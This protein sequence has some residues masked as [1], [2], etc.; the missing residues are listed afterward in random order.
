MKIRRGLLLC[1]SAAAALLA[2]APQVGKAQDQDSAEG[3]DEV[4]VTARKRAEDILQTPVAV[5]VLS[6]ADIDAKGII[7]LT[8]LANNTP[9]FQITSVNSGRNDRSFQQ[10]SLRGFTPS[11]TA[12]TLTAS[13][14]DGV[15]V[16]SAN[17]LNSVTQPARV[18]VLKGPQAAYFGRNAFAGAVNVVTK[19]PGEE[20]GGDLSLMGGSRGYWDLQGSL[21]GPLFSDKLGFRITGRTYSKDGGYANTAVPGQR[22]GDQSSDVFS[23]TLAAQPTDG[24]KIKLFGMLSQDDD[25]PSPEGFIS[26]YELRSNAGVLNIPSRSGSSAGTLIVPN[27]SNCV[28][29]N[30]PWFCGAIP[31]LL[32]GFG[33]AQ[34]SANNAISANSLASGNQ[35]VIDPREGAKGYGL[36]AEFQH[37]HLTIDWDIGDS[38]FTL[39]SLTGIN[40][41]FV[42]QSDD[43]DNWDNSS[44]I[45]PANAMGTN[46]NANTFWNFPFMVEREER[47]F[48]QEFRLSFDRDGPFSGL[49]GVSYLKASA[50]SG[51]LN[52]SAEYTAGM[53][54]SQRAATS[55][56]AVPR[57]ETTSIF[58]GASYEITDQL[59][60]SVEARQQKDDVQSFTGGAGATISAA[61][62]AQ[63]GLRAGAYAPYT[64]LVEREFDHFL[65]RVI[66]DYQFTDDLMGY[67]SWSKGINVALASF[68]TNFLL[69]GS[70]RVLQEATN[71]GLEV[72]FEPEELENYEIGLKGTFFDGRVSGAL[73]IY[74]ADW[75]NQQNNRTSFILDENNV[76][77]VVSGVAN[78]G[79]V[80]AS[81]IELDL[82]AKPTDNVTV[83]FSAAMND[84]D[85]KSF[86]DPLIT[87]VSGVVGAGFRG[88][89]TPLAPKYSANL[90]MQYDGNLTLWEDSSWFAR[91]DVS[92]KG[93]QYVDASNINW[94]ND[95]TQVNV[96]AGVVRGPINIDVFVQNLF[97]N[98]DYVSVAQNNL[99][100]PPPVG[101]LGVGYIN[102][103][104]P[105]RRVYGLR[106][107]YKF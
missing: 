43:L 1:C 21:E 19:T 85:T 95:R 7:S 107:G 103:A 74:R 33:I 35:R 54:P 26:A 25:G 76:N 70:P 39:S 104:L 82:F 55:I 92:Y 77:Q 37:A 65:P 10:I 88:K 16:S 20:F 106:V 105:E 57:A 93:K 89:N 27:Q 84:S 2:S 12:S 47:D 60:V 50:Y 83:Q 62:A 24:L 68:N 96:R 17:A 75:T 34:N 101:S 94:I 23:V 87:G 102:V 71:I 73:A 61:A 44:I 22:L 45:N 63:Y 5:S 8:D 29:N 30:R 52:L 72:F 58:F 56:G 15:P 80:I 42:S 40:E 66:V 13:F 38:G 64:L 97:D 4:V 100:V 86:E 98:D 9:G 51:L 67:V 18:E 31:A 90:G 81:G 49:L 6:G 69:F 46:P 99:Q 78:T 59:T 79:R 91:A 53:L 11:R 41:Y 3:L 14:I 32:P 36:V 48:S 28:R